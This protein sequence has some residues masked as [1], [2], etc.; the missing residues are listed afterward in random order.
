MVLL[1]TGSVRVVVVGGG[2][3]VVSPCLRQLRTIA[4][5]Q[6]FRARAFGWL[7]SQSARSLLHART[8]ARRGLAFPVRGAAAKRREATAMSVRAPNPPEHVREER[9]T[10]AT[11]W[12]YRNSV[13]DGKDDEPHGQGSIP[14]L[15]VK[16]R[17]IGGR[18]QR[19]CASQAIRP[20]RLPAHRPSRSELPH[21]ALITR[22]PA[23]PTVA[24]RSRRGPDSP[25][26]DRPDRLRRERATASRRRL[27]VG[28][29][30]ACSGCAIAARR[31]LA[32]ERSGAHNRSKFP[33]SEGPL[34]FPSRYKVCSLHRRA[35]YPVILRAPSA[36]RAT[37][38]PPGV[39]P[40]QNTSRLSTGT[41][42][43]DEWLR[44]QLVAVKYDQPSA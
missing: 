36:P 38:S 30:V 20:V 14:E 5:R 12:P 18:V 25:R 28:M 22:I 37:S 40:R 41:D 32:N 27:S 11:L 1:A 26:D 19:V 23:W 8:H 7:V 39:G 10:R 17:Q 6:C 3:H 42:E 4:A 24:R 9:W 33:S 35:R 34:R 21:L 31:C 29:P 13:R 15:A 43:E 2:S 16:I 44:N